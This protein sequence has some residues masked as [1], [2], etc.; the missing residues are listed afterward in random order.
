MWILSYVLLTQGVSKIFFHGSQNPRCSESTVLW[1]F[2]PVEFSYPVKLHWAISG[3][4]IWTVPKFGYLVLIVHPALLPE[5]CIRVVSFNRTLVSWSI[6]RVIRLP[7][8]I[9]IS[10]K[11]NTFEMSIIFHSWIFTGEIRGDHLSHSLFFIQVLF[12]FFQSS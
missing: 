10:A 11:P 5:R 8:A 2:G 12:Y 1:P 7:L 9:L 4:R 6:S 3:L